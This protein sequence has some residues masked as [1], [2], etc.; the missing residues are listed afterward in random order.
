MEAELD[1]DTNTDTDNDNDDSDN[2]YEEFLNNKSPRNNQ[3]H[4]RLSTKSS[5]GFGEQ[6]QKKH[7]QVKII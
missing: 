6:L 3:N 7:H 5:L 2:I 4:I 1:T